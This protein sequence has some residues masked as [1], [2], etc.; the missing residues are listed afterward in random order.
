MFAIT[1]EMIPLRRT[2]PRRKQSSFIDKP[3]LTPSPQDR[4]IHRNVLERPFVAK[5]I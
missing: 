3:S 2:C 5:V 1:G 4:L